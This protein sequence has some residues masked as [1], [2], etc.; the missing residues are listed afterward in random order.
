MRFQ[1][2]CLI[3]ILA[4][5]CG[6]VGKDKSSEEKAP[7]ADGVLLTL[8]LT[9][10][11]VNA[12]TSPEDGGS[13]QERFEIRE[14][15]MSR[16]L[17]YFEEAGCRSGDENVVYESVFDAATHIDPPDLAGYT[18]VRQQLRSY[19]ATLLV[20]ARV[21]SFNTKARYGYSDWAQGQAKDISGRKFEEADK[22]STPKIGALRYF[23]MALA[24]GKLRLAKYPDGKTAS[25]STDPEDEFSKLNN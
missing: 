3:S 4:L 7:V 5:G 2:L 16:R 20:A 23:T 1:S 22:R 18:T 10:T 11:W 19:T 24:E 14:D 6:A 21:E 8:G 15:G 9:G 17:T 13:S 25:V 12:C